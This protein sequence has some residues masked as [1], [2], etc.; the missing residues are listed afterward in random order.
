MDMKVQ[1]TSFA[2][3]YRDAAKARLQIF[4]ADHHCHA[5]YSTLV[6]NKPP[7]LQYLYKDMVLIFPMNIQTIISGV[8]DADH[9]LIFAS[10]DSPELLLRHRHWLADGTFKSSPAVF[11]QLF[12]LHVCIEGLVAPAAYALLP[13]KT[14]QTYQ[15]M[16]LEFSKLGQFHP[17][18][19]LTDFERAMI[20]AAQ[21]VFPNVSQSGCFYHFSQCIYRQVQVLDLQTDNKV[22]EFS[23][24]IC[25][26]ATI[27]FVSVS[28]VVD[29]YDTLI[30]AEYP[31]RS[32]IIVDN[33]EDNLIGG[34]DGRGYRR[35]PIFSNGVE[36][37]STCNRVFAPY[38]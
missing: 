8:D 33:F 32:E 3:Q 10:D 5:M 25:M 26:L 38:K 12:T 27:T 18:S 28:Y 30:D 11:Y 24:F 7:Y 21:L 13:N 23:L 35:S 4:R 19:I 31:V 9:K 15:R 2:N 36:C 17:E 14:Q 20:N 22:E 29:E 37:K 16:L 6:V 34:P 1:G